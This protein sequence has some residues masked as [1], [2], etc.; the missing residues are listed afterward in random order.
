MLQGE[1]CEKKSKTSDLD[2]EDEY[3]DELDQ[4]TEIFPSPK[5]NKEEDMDHEPT[6]EG[7]GAVGR[8]SGL[9]VEESL[10]RLIETQDFGNPEFL[11]EEEK[12]SRSYSFG[13]R[14]N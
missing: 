1:P 5:D 11:T 14:F 2:K 13:G 10:R 7:P 8:A 9:T 6:E 3:G 12:R 4:E